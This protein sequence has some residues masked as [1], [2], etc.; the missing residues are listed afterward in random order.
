MCTTHFGPVWFNFYGLLGIF[1]CFLILRSFRISSRSVTVKHMI[2]GIQRDGRRIRFNGQFILSGSKSGVT[3]FLQTQ[4][5][6]KRDTI[7]MFK[8]RVTFRVGNNIIIP[9]VRSH[10]AWVAGTLRKCRRRV[11]RS[12]EMQSACEAALVRV[13]C[14]DVVGK[15]RA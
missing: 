12:T 5:R 9:E 2:F 10:A 11:T 15:Q 6:L 13:G 8:P 7:K 3:F 14:L 4:R 1:Q